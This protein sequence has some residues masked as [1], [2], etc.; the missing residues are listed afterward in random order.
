ML[1]KSPFTLAVFVAVFA[2]VVAFRVENI[3]G[4]EPIESARIVFKYLDARDYEPEYDSDG[5]IIFKRGGKTY[6]L[7]FDEDDDEF[8]RLLYVNFYSYKNE[9]DMIR[10]YVVA[11]LV[12]HKTKVAKL[13]VPKKYVEESKGIFDS[14]VVAIESFNDD[15]HEFARSI[16]RSI[17]AIQTAAKEFSKQMEDADND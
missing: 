15:P 16:Q 14:P 3:F 10:S 17:S 7:V 12:N 5:D 13:V 8:F 1:R 2:S 4:G 9:S 11:N 6:L